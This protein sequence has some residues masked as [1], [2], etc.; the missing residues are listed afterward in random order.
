MKRGFQIAH[1]IEDGQSLLPNLLTV[2]KVRK[3]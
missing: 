1:V 3:C 2:H